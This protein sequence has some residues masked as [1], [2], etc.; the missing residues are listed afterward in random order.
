MDLADLKEQQ[1]RVPVP[2]AGSTRAVSRVT[3]LGRL[4]LANSPLFAEV[5]SHGPSGGQAC[6]QCLIY[7]PS[8]QM[9]ISHGKWPG[10]KA[11]PGA[12]QRGLCPR[13]AVST[14]DVE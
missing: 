8:D 9:G 14:W 1:V 3:H 4:A 7:G 6:L 5:F 2:D 10:C 11:E 13:V 12:P